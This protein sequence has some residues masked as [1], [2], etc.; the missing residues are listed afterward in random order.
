MPDLAESQFWDRQLEDG[1]PDCRL[2]YGKRIDSQITR[3]RMAF[4][5]VYCANCHRPQGLAPVSGTSFV[6]FICDPCVGRQGPPEGV[7][8]VS[9]PEFRSLA[10]CV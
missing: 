5:I 9:M 3:G 8:E 7:H 2:P 4:D 1:L 6:F 10:S